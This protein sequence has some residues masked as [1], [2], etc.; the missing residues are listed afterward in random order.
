M[1]DLNGKVALVTGGTS[2][3]GRATVKRLSRDGARLLFTGSNEE[4]ARSLCEETGAIFVKARVQ[5]EADWTN[6]EQIVAERFGRLDIAF[7]NAGTEQGDGSVESLGLEGWNHII[8]VNQTG[9][10][11]TARSAVKLMRA[12]PGGPGG[13]II[14]NSSMSAHK[15]MGNYMAYSVTKAAVLAMAKSIAI[16]CATEGMPIRCNAILPGVVETEMITAI[17]EKSGAP[18]A[19]RAAYGGMSPMKRMGRV[20]EIAALVSFLASDEA[21][22]INGA[23]YAIDGA[24]TAGMTGV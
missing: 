14:L 6:I 18:E 17:I 8:G 12:N 5:D 4:A 3:I 19:A 15:V 24:S 9:V 22:F 11:L 16:H 10:M 20:E 1:A 2:G 7:A 13:S 23:E 21:G